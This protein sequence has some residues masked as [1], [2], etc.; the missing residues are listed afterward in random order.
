MYYDQKECGRRIAALRKQKGWTQEELAKRIN[1]SYSFISKLELGYFGASVDI[2]LELSS[3]FDVGLEFLVT[4]EEKQCDQIRQQVEMM[5]QQIISLQKM[6]VNM[7]Q[8]LN[9]Q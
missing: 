6:L 9:L 2:L 8:L 3:C 1:V 4:G 5:E 7:K